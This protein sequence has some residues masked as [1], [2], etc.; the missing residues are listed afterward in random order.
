MKKFA[1]IGSI[2]SI[3]VGT[4]FFFT[5]QQSAKANEKDG[6]AQVKEEKKE[7]VYSVELV[8]AKP[9]K[10]H[11][12]VA[13]SATLKADR[14]VDIFSKISG[15]VSELPIEEG[16]KVSKGQ[17]LAE[18]D[19]NDE[20]LRLEQ[21]RV[22]LEKAEAEYQ[23]VA[24]SY[25]KELVSTEEYE[26]KKFDL[27]RQKAEFNLMQHQ[28]E[29][30]RIVAPFSGTIVSRSVELGQTIQP[31]DMLFSLAALDRLEAEVFLPEEATADLREGMSATFS[32]DD[33]FEHAFQGSLNHISPV[34]D[35]QTGTVKIT[36]YID[37]APQGIRPGTYVH[38][39]IVTGAEIAAAVVPKKALVYDG[40]Q[41]TYVF[42]TEPGEAAPDLYEVKKIPVVTG[43]EEDGMISIKEGLAEGAQIVLTGKESLKDG[44]KVRNV[45]QPNTAAIANR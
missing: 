5:M 3:V 10:L 40:K 44:A 42:I 11:T 18:L 16:E 21:N 39:K 45:D 23:R 26:A 31:A 22:A 29:L 17:I 2:V 15:Q 1:V 27:E 28:V 41:N 30:S 7:T 33:D 25:Q 13:S 38:L 8:T 4:V 36:L 37:Q 35:K 6:Q 32:K 14:Q 20:R 43:V 24:R 34:V 19:G 12:Y 9:K